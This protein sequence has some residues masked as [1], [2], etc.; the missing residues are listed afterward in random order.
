MTRKITADLG[1]THEAAEGVL[2]RRS[3]AKLAIGSGLALGLTPMMASNPGRPALNPTQRPDAFVH[4]APDGIVTVHINR[5]EFG[6]G[7]QTGLARILAEELDAD[8]RLVRAVLAPAG[9]AYKDPELGVQM[10]A[11]S[12][13]TRVSFEQYR[14]L[15]GRVRAMLVTAAAAE[16]DVDASTLS[17]R[18]STVMHA[19]GDVFGYGALADKAAQL[20][21]PR[22]VVLKRPAQF[23]LVGK[24]IGRLDAQDKSTGRQ[25]FGI[26]V[27][28]PG[29]KTVLLARP[30]YFGGRVASFDDVAAR[31]VRG[32][33]EVMRVPLDLEAEGIAVVADGY[34]PAKLGRDALAIK[35]RVPDELPDSASLD[36]R[37][38]ALLRQPGMRAADRSKPAPVAAARVITANFTFPFLAHTPIEPL[39]AVIEV[40]ATGAQRR[41]EVWTG[42]QFQS[43]DQA[44]VAAILGLAPEAV[45]LHTQFAGGGFGRRSTPACDYVG[46]TARLMKVWLARG[47][48][49]PLK[50]VWSREDDVRGGYYRPLTKHRAE[51]GLDASG[52][53]VS[54]QHT[55]VSP[56]IL[57]GTMLESFMLKDGVDATTVE[58][59]SDT[60]YDLPIKLDVHHPATAVPVLWWRAVG[61]THTAF[62][63]ETLLDEIAASSGQ[64]PVAMRRHLLAAH[65]RH[66]AALDLAVE[67]SGYGLRS[68][69][70]GRAFGIAMHES[71]SSIVAYVVEVSMRAGRPQVHRVTGAI[72]C[73]MAVNPL[74]VEAQVQGSVVMGL[75][76]LLRGAEITLVDG[77]V[78]QRN[79]DTY[80][81]PRI[82]DVPEV[83]VHI[84]PSMDAPTGA[85]EPGLPPIAPAIANAMRR[86]TGE[87]VRALP[88]R[89]V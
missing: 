11:G 61:H 13:S 62:V 42:T 2:S 31:R 18:E 34:W 70:E 83:D 43:A 41:C 66:L 56:S 65:P 24:P 86:L 72:H 80:R 27:E 37:F 20:Q 23:R 63:M 47:R 46:D 12:R 33:V 49:E 52:Q 60:P 79:F 85:G 25:M 67:K 10:T 29:L 39:N 50:L 44:M 9:D 71:F 73:N 88:L 57:Q 58:G 26:D 28:R 5:L 51:I 82:S 68:L 32:V 38:E 36:E 55:I 15:G 4:I 59:L 21:V 89:D 76:M 45:A 75:G 84:V 7:T 54:W 17:T 14:Q 3:F 1:R 53:V 22:E 87:P 19:N 69:P 30:P 74:S 6:Q 40:T 81:V 64:D 48:S 78:Q 16:W 77:E 35:W 8:W